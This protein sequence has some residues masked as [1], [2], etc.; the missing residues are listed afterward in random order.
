MRFPRR[1]AGNAACSYCAKPALDR[2]AGIV[3]GTLGR[4]PMGWDQRKRRTEGAARAAKLAPHAIAFGDPLRHT[5]ERRDETEHR[6]D[7]PEQPRREVEGTYREDNG[8][9]AD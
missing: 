9:A 2:T 4:G 3:A 7:R 5:L 1:R 8:A 6:H